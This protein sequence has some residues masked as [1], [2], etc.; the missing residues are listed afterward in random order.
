MGRSSRLLHHCHVYRRSQMCFQ[1]NGWQMGSSSPT[2]FPWNLLKR[3]GETRVSV[4]CPIRGN[5]TLPICDLA[6]FNNAY[7]WFKSYHFTHLKWPPLDLPLP[8]S[9]ISVRKSLLL[10]KPKLEPNQ[11]SKK[12]NEL[13]PSL[14]LRTPKNPQIHF[15]LYFDCQSEI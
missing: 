13:S 4:V 8:T 6:R 9:A 2:K 15:F 5:C 3:S 10:Y 11:N 14:Y 1:I 12:R 7:P